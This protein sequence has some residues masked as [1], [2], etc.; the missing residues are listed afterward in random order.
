VLQKGR[1]K[2]TV[3][4][5]H[6]DSHI[7]S[8]E[9][10]RLHRCLGAVA[11][12][13]LQAASWL[14]LLQDSGSV[15]ACSVGSVGCIWFLRKRGSRFLVE[16][17]LACLQHGKSRLGGGLLASCAPAC[18]A[19]RVGKEEPCNDPEENNDGYD[20]NTHNQGD[21]T[22]TDA[23]GAGRLQQ[24]RG[25]ASDGRHDCDLDNEARRGGSGP[26]DSWV[27]AELKHERPKR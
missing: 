17:L 24:T 18:S 13:A 7:A 25:E 19:A 3:C 8:N 14:V 20:A 11:V 16:A 21:G 12:D 5:E 15:G 22:S 23:G 6:P 4:N 1:F 2:S 10:L 9:W 27:G 26:F